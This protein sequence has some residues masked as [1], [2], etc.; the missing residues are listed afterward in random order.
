MVGVWDTYHANTQLIAIATHIHIN[1]LAKK[2]LVSVS[3]VV[4]VWKVER[5]MRE[6]IS[7][8]KSFLW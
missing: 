7:K 6:Y 4:C 5:S 3:R 2:L 1:T 8:N